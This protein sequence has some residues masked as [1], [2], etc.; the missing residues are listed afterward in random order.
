[1]LDS[2]SDRQGCPPYIHRHQHFQFLNNSTCSNC[3][4]LARVQLH[5]LQVTTGYNS[6]TN[7]WYPSRHVCSVVISGLAM[8]SLSI[9]LRMPHSHDDIWAGL[10]PSKRIVLSR[11]WKGPERV[12]NIRALSGHLPLTEQTMH[13]YSYAL[14]YPHAERL[15]RRHAKK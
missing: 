11:W 5:T 4:F 2:V 14:I 6:T 10:K 1:M 12:Q 7:S 8:T 9:S 3:L 13:S 15:N